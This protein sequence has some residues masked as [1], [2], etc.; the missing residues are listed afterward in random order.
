MTKVL[1]TVEVEDEHA[2]PDHPCGL[3]NEAY[4]RLTSYGDHG[5]PPLTWLGEI[6][7]VEVAT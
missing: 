5:A 7:D 2:D 1:I 3:T 6:D 4:E